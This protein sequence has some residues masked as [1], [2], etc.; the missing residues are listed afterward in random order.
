MRMLG[1]TSTESFS[2]YSA[3]AVGFRG[4]FMFVYTCFLFAIELVTAHIDKR[5]RFNAEAVDYHRRAYC[6]RILW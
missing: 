5:M 4:Q 3:A 2:L 1:M 6:A